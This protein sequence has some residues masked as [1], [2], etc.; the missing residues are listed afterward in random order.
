MGSPCNS[1]HKKKSLDNT[2]KYCFCADFGELD[3]LEDPGVDGRII[4]RWIF[5]KWN[6]GAWTGSIWLRTGMDVGLL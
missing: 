6:V 4:L 1:H 2:T 3:H 5:W